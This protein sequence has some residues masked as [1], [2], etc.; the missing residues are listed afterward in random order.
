MRVLEKKEG[1]GEKVQKVVAD[2]LCSFLTREALVD[3]HEK[4]LTQPPRAILL[5]SRQGPQLKDFVHSHFVFPR[6]RISKPA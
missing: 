5:T 1:M 3:S 2:I 6:M 4:V